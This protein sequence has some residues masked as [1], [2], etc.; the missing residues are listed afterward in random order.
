MRHS[1]RASVK[2]FLQ[3]GRD[4]NKCLIKLKLAQKCWTFTLLAKRFLWCIFTPG[5][6][7]GVGNPAVLPAAE[8]TPIWVKHRVSY[9]WCWCYMTV[10]PGGDI[11]FD[12]LLTNEGPE[13]F[14][15]ITTAV[16]IL[17]SAD[18]CDVLQFKC[19]KEQMFPWFIQKPK[20]PQYI[21]KLS[22]TVFPQINIYSKQHIPKS[23]KLSSSKNLLWSCTH[24]H[25]FPNVFHIAAYGS[26]WGR[27]SNQWGPQS[28]RPS[29][30]V[31]GR[32]PWHRPFLHT[33]KHA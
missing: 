20:S 2:V 28:P 19:N 32:Q 21:A 7:D 16:N 3:V 9:G 15:V 27:K 18:L 23:F 4:F 17:Q 26:N 11:H 13:Y 12:T 14:H 30:R 1:K 29:L 25:F 10:C 22:P 24:L 5:A 6:L 31:S 8:N 33:N